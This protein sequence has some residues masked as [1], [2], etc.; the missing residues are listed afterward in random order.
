MKSIQH[1]MIPW[2]D[3]TIRLLG[4]NTTTN[5]QESY[6][7]IERRSGMI[8]CQEVKLLRACVTKLGI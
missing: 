7:T 1:W 8:G 6:L 5:S 3:W 4:N 2:S